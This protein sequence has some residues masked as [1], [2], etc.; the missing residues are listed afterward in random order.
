MKDQVNLFT[1]AE[2]MQ[3]KR[4]E[5][6]ENY[7]Q[8]VNPGY[9]SLLS[10]LNLDKHFVKAEGTRLWDLDGQ[11]YLDFLAGF[12][13]QNFGHNNPVI[14]ESIERVKALPNLVQSSL[15]PLAGAL[16]KN[17]AALLPGDLKNTFFC[18]SGTEAVEAALKL[19]RIATGK[20]HVVTTESSFH[21]KTIGSL[22]VTGRLKYLE[23]FRP[24]MPEI[25]IVPF[26]NAEAL[27][28]A[29][30]KGN[31]A[32]FIIE[33][34]QGEGGINV[35][36]A[37]FLRQVRDLCSKYD[38]LLILDEVQTGFGRT[39]HNFAME[40]EGIVPDIV[41]LGKSLGGGIMPIGA[42][43][44]TEKLWNKAY[45][46]IERCTLHTSTFGGNA[47]AMA[48]GIAATNLLVEEELA[49]QA[50][51]KG[52]YLL[53]AVHKMK[54]KYE[55]IRDV[56]G[57]GLFIGIEFAPAKGVLDRITGAI[58]EKVTHDYLGSLM[59]GELF[60]QHRIVTAYTLNNPNVIRLEPPLTVTY[61]EM[62]YLLEALDKV[63][64]QKSG[65]LGIA[66]KGVANKLG[67]I[68]KK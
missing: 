45:G 29:L 15:S 55:L 32:A 33:P 51:E 6:L 39:G 60:N 24:L 41:C 47:W 23:P 8:Y 35:P 12:G 64:S 52:E 40:E 2:A 36:P 18:N 14:I 17:L 9:V 59:T 46:G 20:V 66:A 7:K 65:M 34:I 11:V 49:K 10:L 63:S 43:T 5:V 22:S 4:K 13:S 38:T 48:A 28:K 25:S 42:M 16:A 3:F 1:L 21:G 61:E 62:D 37:G 67:S 44:T 58:G 27:E 31:C 26:G 19:A 57:K 30:A 54:E 53:R 68:F 56:R 50:R